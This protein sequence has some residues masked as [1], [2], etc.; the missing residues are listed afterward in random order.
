MKTLKEFNQYI[1]KSN[2]AFKKSNKSRRRVLIARDV[3]ERIK[4]KNIYANQGIICRFNDRI[5]LRDKDSLKDFVNNNI[6]SCQTCAK[7]SMFISYVGRVNKFTYGEFSHDL[8]THN[9]NEMQKLLELFSE[10]QLAKIEYAFEGGQYVWRD[11]QGNKIEI[12]DEEADKMDEF[13]QE[14]KKDD[15]LR[16][17]KICENII[18]NK[19]TYIP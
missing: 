5:S 15:N 4:L 11:S 8:N 19:G 9:C 7:G 12:S 17:I 14:Y 3:I 10:E 13:Y 16:M 1:E 2:A 18:S 6:N